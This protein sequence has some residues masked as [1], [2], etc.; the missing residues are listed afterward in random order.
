MAASPC[1]AWEQARSPS[2]PW[3]PSLEELHCHYGQKIGHIMVEKM[4]RVPHESSGRAVHASFG[5]IPAAQ[6]P[7]H[8]V[9]LLLIPAVRTRSKFFNY[10]MAVGTFNHIVAVFAILWLKAHHNPLLPPWAHERCSEA[11]QRVVANTDTKQAWRQSVASGS[12]GAACTVVQSIRSITAL[13]G[14]DGLPTAGRQAVKARVP[15]PCPSP[16]AAGYHQRICPIRLPRVSSR[17][18]RQYGA[19]LRPPRRH[20]SPSWRAAHGP[21]SAAR[22]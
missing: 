9:V 2:G 14:L 13:T 16:G 17:G 1:G 10:I 18:G 8:P 19:P 7:P 12:C 21:A 5:A 22:D 15:A 6:G 11:P 20:R 4:Q 3:W